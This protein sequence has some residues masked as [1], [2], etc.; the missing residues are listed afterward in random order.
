MIFGIK[1][2]IFGCLDLAWFVFTIGFFGI[3]M[4]MSLQSANLYL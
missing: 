2:Y 4:T 3:E 1:I